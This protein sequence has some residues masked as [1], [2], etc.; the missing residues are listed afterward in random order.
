MVRRVDG[1]RAAGSAAGAGAGHGG[2]S[3]VDD[4]ARRVVREARLVVVRCHRVLNLR[5][6]DTTCNHM[7]D[8][9]FITRTSVM[10]KIFIYKIDTAN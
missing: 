6:D 9:A 1:Y 7:G 10:Y 5:A 2:R 4:V 8:G 3:E